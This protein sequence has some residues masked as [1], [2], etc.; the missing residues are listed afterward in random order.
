MRILPLPPRHQ[1]QHRPRRIRHPRPRRAHRRIIPK[2]RP[3]SLRTAIHHRTSSPST[4]S[5]DTAAPPQH[6]PARYTNPHP[7]SSSPLHPHN[8]AS[9]NAPQAIAFTLIATPRPRQRQRIHIVVIPHRLMTSQA[10]VIK[11]RTHPIRLQLRTLE[12]RI[13]PSPSPRILHAMFLHELHLHK[14]PRHN[15]PVP[16]VRRL[17][18]NLRKR[19]TL[20]PRRQLVLLNR[21]HRQIIP[22]NNSQR[23]IVSTIGSAHHPPIRIPRQKR[24]PI[25][26]RR[27]RRAQM[28]RRLTCSHATRP[29][30]PA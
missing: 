1:S 26:R 25:R 13:P 6:P 30:S 17:K 5:P 14:L 29:R 15:M 7:Q 16:I 11:V 24:H 20:R 9:I 8:T 4:P 3:R 10:L 12:P 2:Q 21:A 23:V 19:R 22:R 28:F 27:R 18:R